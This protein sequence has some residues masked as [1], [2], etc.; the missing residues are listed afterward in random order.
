[1]STVADIEAVSVCVC[2]CV[3]LAWMLPVSRFRG[4]SLFLGLPAR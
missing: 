1:M 2:V 3:K 4:C